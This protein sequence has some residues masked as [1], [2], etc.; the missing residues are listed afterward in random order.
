MIK[1]IKKRISN[2]KGLT[3]VEL[4]IVVA[5]IGILSV[6]GITQ[7]GGVTDTAKLS[8][9]KA[10]AA[11]IANAVKIYM[12][13][14]GVEPPTIEGNKFAALKTYLDSDKAPKSQS[15][16]GVDFTYTVAN[17]NTVTVKAGDV[18]FYPGYAPAPTPNK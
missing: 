9:D 14:E 7:F 5:I 15:E 2:N 11:E 1:A 13:T 12:A 4:V 6:V 3:L 10:T 16:E 17:D 8:A 18:T